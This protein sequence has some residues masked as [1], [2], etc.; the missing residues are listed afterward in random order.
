MF[1]RI[2]KNKKKIKNITGRTFS[3]NFRR[4]PFNTNNL[5][6]KIS[7]QPKEHPLKQIGLG[8]HNFH[9]TRQGLPPAGVGF[10]G[11][12]MWALIYPFIEQQMLYESL[13]SRSVTSGSVTAKGFG[14]PCNGAWW[15]NGLNDS[16]RRSFASVSPYRCPSRRGSG[17]QM[18]TTG[19]TTGATRN[20]VNESNDFVNGPCSD[21]GMVFYTRSTA[22]HNWYDC[23][24]YL[25]PNEIPRHFGPFRCAAYQEPTS[26]TALTSTVTATS[27]PN[28]SAVVASWVPRDTM[29]WW[30]DGS[31]NQFIVGEKHIAPNYLGKCEGSNAY[32]SDCSYLT[33]NGWKTS[34]GG[35]GI[36]YG[37]TSFGIVLPNYGNDNDSLNPAFH[38]GFGSYHSGICQFLLGDASVRTIPVTITQSILTRLCDTSDG[39]TVEIPN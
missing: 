25:D 24:R 26:G 14:V 17:V 3:R 19:G 11:A 29:S 36:R 28:E 10:D 22:N 39:E 15:L 30:Q 23:T 27:L 12:S 1:R 34:G 16:E 8:V 21:Y 5:N 31:T 13:Y 7:T 6:K 2:Y 37:S 33:M 20:N 18:T 35:R 9:D 38:F 4:K 32:R